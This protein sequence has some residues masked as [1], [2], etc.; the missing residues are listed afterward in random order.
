[1]SLR[2]HSVVIDCHDVAAQAR[3]WAGVLDWRISFET[4]NEMFWQRDLR[5]LRARAV[6]RSW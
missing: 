1:M 5:A 2:W 3:W 6:R 4:N